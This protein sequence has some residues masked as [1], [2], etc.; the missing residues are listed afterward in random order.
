MDMFLEKSKSWCWLTRA[1]L[2]LMSLH[3]W[4]WRPCVND[5]TLSRESFWIMCSTKIK[6]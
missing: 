6:H 2:F 3:T 4:S 5:T 1:R